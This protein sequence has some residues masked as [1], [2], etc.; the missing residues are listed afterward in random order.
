MSALEDVIAEVRTETKAAAEDQLQALRDRGAEWTQTLREVDD[1]GLTVEL[2]ADTTESLSV[3]IASNVGDALEALQE[4]AKYLDEIQIALF[5]RTGAGKSSFI[6][7]LTRGTGSRVSPD[8][9]LDFT[10]KAEVVSW[11]GARLIDTPGIEGWAESNERTRIERDA[12][13]AVQRADIVVLAFDDYNQKIGEFRQIAQWVARLGKAAIAVLNIR[14]DAWRYDARL[15]HPDDREASVQQVRE[16]ARH[17][18]RMLDTVGLSSVPVIATNLAWAFGARGRSLKHHPAA[19]DLSLGRKSLGRDGLLEVSNFHVV[20]DF[21]VELLTDDPAGLRLGTLRREQEAALANLEEALLQEQQGAALRASQI[22]RAIEAVLLRTGVPTKAQIAAIASR[23][24]RLKIEGFFE[25]LRDTRAGRPRPRNGQV[26]AVLDDHLRAPL[27]RAE[28]E[29][30]RAAQELLRQKAGRR[31][32]VTPKDLEKE[33]LAAAD[34]EGNARP[35]V[36][37]AFADLVA[38]IKS[39]AEDLAADFHWEVEE[40]TASFEANAGAWKRYAGRIGGIAVAG[41]AAAIAVLNPVFWGV[42]AA[43]GVGVVG[44]WLTRKLR[45][46]GDNDR[47]KA[48]LAAERDVQAWL[49]DASESVRQHSLLIVREAAWLLAADSQAKAARTAVVERHIESA[50]GEVCA[51]IEM[52]RAGLLDAPLASELVLRALR[53]I[54]DR[55]FPSDPDAGPKTWLGEDWLDKPMGELLSESA[56]PIRPAL[57]GKIALPE[58]AADALDAF[59]AAAHN[60]AK[61][62]PRLERAVLDGRSV[63]DAPPTVVFAGDYSAGKTSLIRRAAVELGAPLDID[64]G[65]FRIGGDPTTTETLAVQAADLT[66]CD[67]PGLNSENADHDRRAQQAAAAAAVIVVAHTPV[68]GK[69]DPVRRLLET[70]TGLGRSDR[71]IHVL[72]HIDALSARPHTDP[73]GFMS[74]LAAKRN[75]LRERLADLGLRVHP[76]APL[77]VA[78]DPGGRHARSASWRSDDFELHRGWDGVEDL[79][80]VITRIAP[81]GVPLAAVDR[82]LTSLSTL[83]V[84]MDTEV[85]EAALRE[86]EHRRVAEILERAVKRHDR[87]ELRAAADLRAVVEGAISDRLDELADMSRK[88]LARAQEESQDWLVTPELEAGFE[89]WRRRTGES[90]TKIYADLEHSLEAR[91]HSKAF[92]KAFQADGNDPLTDSLLKGAKDFLGSAAGRGADAATIAQQIADRIPTLAPFAEQL[93]KAAARGLAIAAGVLLEVIF[94]ALDERQQRKRE[95]ELEDA[96]RAIAQA[97]DSWVEATL[98]GA[99]DVPGVL[100]GLIAAKEQWLEAPLAKVRQRLAEEQSLIQDL[101]QTDNAAQSLIQEGSNALAQP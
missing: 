23:D 60:A 19:R 27:A 32:T 99:D 31:K 93:G 49:R 47:V 26:S 11:S 7:A 5:G 57:G 33:A 92:G 83:R 73:D 42:A 90:A 8:G 70:G 100:D 4:R 14:D 95:R 67:T 2:D 10:R 84:E 68:S 38:Q 12:Q 45:K 20:L 65:A 41:G 30:L 78:A 24:E 74:L 13:E 88:Q 85:A 36:V 89:A 25:S 94:Q 55:R 75:E 66:L 87:L 39:E 98:S 71:A 18:Q 77:P 76:D 53:A 1:D 22:E 96:K 15:W 91:V 61:E 51:S 62:H 63:L 46:S 58:R 21:I 97:G 34:F 59:W 43:V 44:G 48:R 52:T 6:E 35:A 64:A 3:L 86:R 28:S 9:R 101:R 69:L 50:I 82:T 54:E 79:L 56:P 72:S 17:T 29:G 80:E 40:L 37:A 16:H 81:A